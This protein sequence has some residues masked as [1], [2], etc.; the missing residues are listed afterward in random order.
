[1]E[2]GYPNPQQLDPYG[3]PRLANPMQGAI[4]AS[5]DQGFLQWLFDFR[6]EAIIP[7]R[8]SWQGKEFDFKTKEWNPSSSK[9]KVMNDDG[10]I[11]GIS[12]IESW[13]N[14]AFIVTDMDEKTY[15]F[16]MREA[17]RVIWNNLCCRYK[18]FG[19]KKLDISRV[20]GEIESKISAILLGA[21]NDG[22][23]RFFSTQHSVS[24]SKNL[25]TDNSPMNRPGI[26]SRMASMFKG[27]DQRQQ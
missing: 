23:R 12:Y 13:M 22:Y 21:R 6:K 17:S 25:N 5:Q 7:L 11:W 3:F 1:M 9:L 8:N 19:L 10:I 26:F 4:L 14:P 20:A 24:E 2:V 27:N 16:S 18:E 15:N